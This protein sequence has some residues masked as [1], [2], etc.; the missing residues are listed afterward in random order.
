MLPY[1]VETPIYFLLYFYGFTNFEN[2]L[3]NPYYAAVL[4]C[5]TEW[6]PR[7]IFPLIAL[8]EKICLIKLLENIKS[9]YTTA[10]ALGYLM[11]LVKWAL[12]YKVFQTSE[13]LTLVA[14]CLKSFTSPVSD[15]VEKQSMAFV[16]E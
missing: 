13:L 5:A 2:K 15:G 11:L 4:T 8:N 1:N 7:I 3:L 6:R 16:K 12:N 14:C 10:K 9:C